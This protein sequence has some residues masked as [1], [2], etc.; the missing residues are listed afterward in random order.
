M[1]HD[2]LVGCIAVA[3]ISTLVFSACGSG[4]PVDNTGG[5]SGSGASSGSSSGSGSG[6]GL[7]GTDAAASETCS[8]AGQTQT[9][10]TG[11][12]SKRGV[13]ACHGG[14]QQCIAQGSGETTAFAWGPCTGE[15]TD[16]GSGDAGGGRSGT[17]ACVPTTCADLGANCGS[18][19]DGCG[20]RLECGACPSG[21]TCSS[22]GKGGGNVCTTTCVPPKTCADLGANC[23]S[24]DDGCG[25]MID[26][27]AC[28]SGQTCGGGGTANQCGSAGCGVPQW[29]T[30]CQF[31]GQ[32]GL[33]GC[34]G[35][36]TCNT[37]ATCKPCQY[38]GATVCVPNTAIGAL[39]YS[40]TCGA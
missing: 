9:C 24:A 25:T 7:F 33:A 13:G 30:C 38:A 1:R 23:G 17:D 22:P 29:P 5:G 27:G 3:F 10:W 21:Q 36:G 39:Q 32:P 15:Q 26:C 40:C 12:P 2:R 34:S 18:A 20:G 31:T 11:D 16:C 6:S 37:G 28:P 14:V 35:G 19:D 8:Q 4:A